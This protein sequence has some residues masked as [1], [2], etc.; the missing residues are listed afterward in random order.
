MWS[1]V[2]HSKRQ[3]IPLGSIGRV[4]V[5]VIDFSIKWLVRNRLEGKAVCNRQE[6]LK[7]Q[8]KAVKREAQC[9][10]NR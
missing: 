5:A 3:L 6:V 7:S 8:E 1:L 9:S 2:E 10:A 4:P